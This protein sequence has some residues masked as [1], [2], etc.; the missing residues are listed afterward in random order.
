M[1]GNLKSVGISNWTEVIFEADKDL[2]LTTF[3]NRKDFRKKF[4]D[5]LAENLYDD[6]RRAR[7]LITAPFT[8]NKTFNKLPEEEKKVWHSYAESIPE[9]LKLLNLYIR[10]FKEYCASCIITDEEIEILAC[11][12]HDIFSSSA[13]PE[14]IG[15]EKKQKAG[16]KTVTGLL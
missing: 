16:K 1:V 3:V 8:F 4:I 14:E 7:V 5:K 10:P 12:D 2:F 13:F 11:L 9:K 15:E 6:M